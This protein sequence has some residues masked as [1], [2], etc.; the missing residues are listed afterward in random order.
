M[1]DEEFFV[2]ISTGSHNILIG[3]G[4]DNDVIVTNATTGIGTSI[5]NG[6]ITGITLA[7]SETRYLLLES[8]DF[9][10]LE[11]GSKIILQR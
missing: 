8:G 5:I 7:P 3:L 6:A 1:I 11:D 9:I 4:I 2:V 10:L